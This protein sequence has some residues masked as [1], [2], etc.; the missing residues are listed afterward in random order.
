M[1]FYGMFLAALAWFQTNWSVI[2]SL[3]RNLAADLGALWALGLALAAVL[4][5]FFP[6]SPK[7]ATLQAKLIGVVKP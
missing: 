4:K 2:E 6:Q 7:G 1:D 3:A 5:K